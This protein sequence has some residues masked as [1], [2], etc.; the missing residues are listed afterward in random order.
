MRIMLLFLILIGFATPS[1][2]EEAKTP[3][4]YRGLCT[5]HPQFCAA[6]KA[7]KGEASPIRYTKKVKRVLE[8]VNTH[9]NSTIQSITDWELYR[10]RELWVGAQ[11]RGDCEEYAIAKKME[12]LQR[13]FSASQLLYAVV[14]DQNNEG[15]LVLLVRTTQGVLVLDNQRQEIVRFEESGYPLKS[16]QRP[17][18][19]YLWQND[20]IA[21]AS[22]R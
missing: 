11:D 22:A 9:W 12:L 14:W 17:D 20:P 1:F 16:Y 7:V 10:E 4:G 6:D 18:A 15:H 19:P 5:T 3:I 2:S 8:E 21:T 13:G